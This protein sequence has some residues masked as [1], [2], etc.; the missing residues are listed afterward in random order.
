M[1]NYFS[2]MYDDI[3]QWM[4]DNLKYYNMADYNDASD[5]ESAVYDDLWIADSV[6]GNGSGSYFFNRFKALDAISD[7]YYLLKEA[8]SEFGCSGD[9]LMDKLDDAETLDVTIRCYILSQVLGEWIH[10][11][12]SSIEE[13]IQKTQAKEE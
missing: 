4:E 6:T 11:N 3:D 5:F 13:A 7:N 9:W 1:Y 10:N 12:E 8:C 2:Q